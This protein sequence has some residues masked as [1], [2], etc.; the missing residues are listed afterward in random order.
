MCVKRKIMCGKTI[1]FKAIQYRKQT[2]TNQNNIKLCEFEEETGCM[3][4]KDLLELGTIKQPSKKLITIF[5]V[6]M[7]IDVDKIICSKW[8]GLLNLETFKNFQKMIEHNG[9]RLKKL[10]RK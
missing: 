2:K 9:L 7:E 6:E 10:K 1:V 3:I 4:Q 8:S 5:A